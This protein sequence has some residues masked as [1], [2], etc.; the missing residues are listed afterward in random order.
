MTH[1]SD[2]AAS[3]RRAENQDTSNR[4]LAR[5][6]I[7][8][9]AS[10]VG[11]LCS[12][13]LWIDMKVIPAKKQMSHA[14]LFNDPKLRDE[15][16]LFPPTFQQKLQRIKKTTSS[17]N[18]QSPAGKEGSH[19]NAICEG[20]WECRVWLSCPSIEQS[21]RRGLEGP[22][23]PKHR[24]DFSRCTIQQATRNLKCENQNNRRGQ[25]HG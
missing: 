9:I 23:E 2:V 22:P 11:K 8:G 13:R 4:T 3:P 20:V 18:T 6:C 21:T 1:R 14:L 24:I 15:N 25:V 12:R 5:T 16:S 19:Q 7:T 17:Y 10:R